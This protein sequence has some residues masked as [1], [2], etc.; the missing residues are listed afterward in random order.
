M[1]LMNDF[2]AEPKE[3]KEVM[4][5]ATRRV[6]ESGWYVL[7]SEVAQFER[8]WAGRCGVEHGVGVANGM[9]AIEVA[10][11]A[12]GIGEGDEVITSAMTAFPT[13]LAIYR[14]GATPVLADIDPTTALLDPESV[15]SCISERTRGI[16]LVHLYGQIRQMMVWGDLCKRYGIELIE[17]CAQSHLASSNGKVA[18]SFGSA[19][20]YSFYPT[21][22][23]GAI[24]DGGML[25]TGDRALASKAFMLRNYGQS[26][27]YHHPVLGMNSRLDEI[28]AAVLSERLHWLDE[29]TER[30][31]QIASAYMSEIK[32][33]HIRNMGLPE[34]YESHVYHLYVVL[35]EDRDS[36]QLHLEKKGV[37]SLIHYPIPI[38]KQEPCVGIEVAPDGTEN[39][40]RHARSCLSLPCHPQ[41]TDLDT[42]KVI[43]AVNSFKG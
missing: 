18:G 29:F 43:D 36:L 1:V 26:D 33:K 30:R 35:C 16:V 5:A 37:Q 25:V 40:E 15:E 38:H 12:L 6:I 22:N 9:D 24:G 34:S 17:D 3:L 42:Q 28:H 31:K 13:V 14:A 11:R 19:G 39:A 20:A 27:R 23:L 10:L 4:L 32:N 7:G 2:K 41:M 8:L 21:K